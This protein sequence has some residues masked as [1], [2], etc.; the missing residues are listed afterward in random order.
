MVSTTTKLTAK[1]AERGGINF[2]END[3]QIYERFEIFKGFL[4]EG[5]RRIFGDFV[6]R[7]FWNFGILLERFLKLLELLLETF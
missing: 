3:F 1:R 4:S 5:K 7:L 2:R 6:A